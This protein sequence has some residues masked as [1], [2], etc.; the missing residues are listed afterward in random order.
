[1]KVPAATSSAHSRSYS[2]CE[3][4]HQTMRSGFARRAT[5]DTH[6]RRARWRTHEGALDWSTGAA[7]AFISSHSRKAN[8]PAQAGP[9]DEDYFSATI[10]APRLGWA[11]AGPLSLLEQ[12][13]LRNRGLFS[14]AEPR[15]DFAQ[16]IIGAEFASDAAERRMRQAQFFGEEFPARRLARG[17]RQVGGGLS[18]G[19]QVALPGEEHRFAARRPAG[20]QQ[21]P[22]A[23]RFE[24]LAGFRR[25]RD[26]AFRRHEA[27]GQIQLV[28][29]VDARRRRGHVGQFI[30]NPARLEHGDDQIGAFELRLRAL[31]AETLDLV[32]RFAQARGIDHY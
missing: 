22:L 12:K 14:D 13:L 27:R 19:A 11:L 28:V 18:Q 30:A 6:W 17:G 10:L 4:S 26:G 1:M 31:H 2:A 3:P 21:N 23:Q 15:E 32:A 5:S 29:H 20:G 25:H 24:A 7:G 8:G 16:Q 9:G